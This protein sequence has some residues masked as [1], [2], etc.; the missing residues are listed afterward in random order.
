MQQ[1]LLETKSNINSGLEH[2]FRKLL[3]TD[4]GWDVVEM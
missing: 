1:D 2:F 3:S 4:W